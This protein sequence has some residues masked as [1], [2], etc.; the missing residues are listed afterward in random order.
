MKKDWQIAEEQ[1]VAHWGQYG[2]R[3]W[4]HRFSDTAQAIGMNG[5]KAI[6]PAQPSDFLVVHDGLTMLAEVKHSADKTSFSHSG[7]RPK[8]MGCARMSVP[9]GGTYLFFIKAKVLGVWFCVPASVILNNRETKSTKWADI[10]EY[11]W[12]INT[13]IA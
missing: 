12:D 4:V 1:F 9:A 6:A 2:K 7:I 8:Q 13:R 10:M 5:A 3:A 11:Q